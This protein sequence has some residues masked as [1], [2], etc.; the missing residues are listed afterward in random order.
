MAADDQAVRRHGR[1]TVA[2]ALLEMSENA[3]SAPGAPGLS[4]MTGHDPAERIRRLINTPW[5]PVSRMVPALTL[6]LTF[7]LPAL[8]VA[9]A[10]TPAVLLADTA[11][12]ISQGH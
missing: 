8:P 11:H 4:A 2:K 12:P 1:R 10:V 6:S 9:G 7:A 3:G 5:R